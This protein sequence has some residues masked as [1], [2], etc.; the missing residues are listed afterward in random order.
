MIV[1]FL[2]YDIDA[3]RLNLPEGRTLGQFTGFQEPIH[4]CQ[5]IKGRNE[6]IHNKLCWLDP[7]VISYYRF[8]SLIQSNFL[9]NG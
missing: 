6:A 1:L 3:F 9:K 4:F 2:L 5:T 8:L 7:P